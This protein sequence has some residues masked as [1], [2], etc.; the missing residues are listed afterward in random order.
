MS[1]EE[2]RGGPVLA[3]AQSS[4]F[5]GEVE[6]MPP[7]R[8]VGQFVL[9]L[10]QLSRVLAFPQIAVWIW[11]LALLGT[12]GLRREG[13][14]TA[15]VL[16]VLSTAG[17]YAA[18]TT[19]DD[20]VGFRNGSDAANYPPGTD[21]KTLGGKAL[22]NGSVTE[23]EARTF[24]VVAQAVATLAAV[25]GFAVLGWHVPA[26]AALILMAVVVCAVQYSAGPLRFSYW[27]GGAEIL[28]MLVRVGPVLGMYLALGGELSAQSVLS[29]SV[30]GLWMLLAVSCG[31]VSDRE[32][33][34]NVGRRTL[35]VVVGSA[36]TKPLLVAYFLADGALLAALVTL[37]PM[38][39]WSSLT[40]LP[41]LGAHAIQLWVC[42]RRHDWRL[43]WK[44][45]VLTHNLGFFGLLLPVVAL[46]FS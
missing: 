26:T 25:A 38:P 12:E 21:R 42:L 44:Y 34:G 6:G 32:A 36:G 7:R 20:I 40:V 16:F 18:G 1:V 46:S 3:P 10:V 22:L 23:R 39:W 30:L 27:P 41:T 31:N 4:G 45:G 11:P 28:V 15:W 43:G 17:A 14:L 9:G 5:S 19:V 13:A 2:T 33:D 8:T 29:S 37:T 24:A 35:G